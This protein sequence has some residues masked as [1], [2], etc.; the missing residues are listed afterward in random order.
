MTYKG[1]AYVENGIVVSVHYYDSSLD[2]IALDE[3]PLVVAI[4]EQ[5]FNVVLVGWSYANGEFTQ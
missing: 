2:T 5:L 3:H 4:P 1:Y